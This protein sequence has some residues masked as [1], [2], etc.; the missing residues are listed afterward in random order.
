MSASD[1]RAGVH[2]YTGT[3]HRYKSIG[4]AY[5]ALGESGVV[6]EHVYRSG[7]MGIRGDFSI[8]FHPRP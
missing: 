6:Y 2:G 1:V 8:Y 3:Q 4:V 5:T 7:G